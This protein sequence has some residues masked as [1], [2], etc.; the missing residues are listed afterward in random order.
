MTVPTSNGNGN[1]HITK[2]TMN[3]STSQSHTSRT[4]TFTDSQSR[5]TSSRTVVGS[6]YDHTHIFTADQQV[7]I[8]RQTVITTRSKLIGQ[9]KLSH[10][11]EEYIDSM[12]LESFVEYI[13]YERLT[14]MP[15]R[16]SRWDKVLKWAEFFAAQIGDYEEVV[17]PFVRSSKSASRLIWAACRVLI[18]VSWCFTS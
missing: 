6:G 2:T 5:R 14:N 12:T 16:G 8:L 10:I 13:E 4:E 11:N 7:T 3:A 17:S 15:H 9:L 18:E 1:G